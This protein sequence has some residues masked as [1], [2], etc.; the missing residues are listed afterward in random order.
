MADGESKRY[1][2]TKQSL[3]AGTSHEWIRKTVTALFAADVRTIG[4][5]K[6]SE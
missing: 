3:L 2:A 6:V 1:E 4:L 5:I